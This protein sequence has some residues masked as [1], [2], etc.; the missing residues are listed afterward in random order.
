MFALVVAESLTVVPQTTNLGEGRWPV[1]GPV[2]SKD[3]NPKARTGGLCGF[4]YGRGT[5]AWV[6][7]GRQLTWLV[8]SVDR[9]HDTVR[10]ESGRAFFREGAGPCRRREVLSRPGFKRGQL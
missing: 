4:A 6:D 5:S 9:P 2:V 8:V 3:W 1:T 7:W 10:M